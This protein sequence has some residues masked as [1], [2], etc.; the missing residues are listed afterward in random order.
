VTRMTKLNEL[1]SCR[2]AKLLILLLL[3]SGICAGC[4]GQDPLEARVKKLTHSLGDKDQNVSYASVYALV[5]I[6]E[7]AVDSLIKSFKR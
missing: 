4:L 3:L 2:H 7:P 1:F 5:D 6:G